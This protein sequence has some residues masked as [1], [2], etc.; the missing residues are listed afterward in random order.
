[1]ADST[2]FEVFGFPLVQ[3]DPKTALAQPNSMV[4]T[5]AM[6]HKYFGNANPLGQT[7][8]L[9]NRTDYKVT[10]VL[11]DVSHNTHL[12]FDFL[13]SLISREQSAGTRWV[14]N[15]Y[16]TYILLR[17]GADPEQLEAK[18]P[19]LVRK[20]VAPQIEQA[21]GKSYDEAVAAGAKWDFFLQ[22]LPDI[23]WRADLQY[24]IGATS[25][26][27][28]VYILMAIAA[29]ILLIAC[30][31]FMNL[32]TARASN[33]AKEV[34]MRKVLGSVRGQLIKQ[35]LSEAILMACLAM[36]IACC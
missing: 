5:E 30:I 28:Y 3:G 22:P 17:P 8:R 10:G 13:A 15:N 34:G 4:L 16:Y 21:L 20:Y 36:L 7:L 19:A 14:S 29:F 9:D 23:Y 35:F 26:L 18:F 31:N 25:D 11:Q 12:R 33:R 27:K 1:V 6:S 32:A 24:E 2:A